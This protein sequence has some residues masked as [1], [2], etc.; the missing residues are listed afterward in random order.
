M[1][2]RSQGLFVGKTRHLARHHMPSRQ[3]VNETIKT[4]KVGDTVAIVPKG[5]FK[6]IPHPRYKGKVGKVVERRGTGYVVEV[7]IFK[8][9]KRLVIPVM[10][11][12][13]VT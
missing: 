8:S 12:T 4:F 3:N 6:N 10:H 2:K 9:V 11:L 5:N 13:K 7:N 1:T